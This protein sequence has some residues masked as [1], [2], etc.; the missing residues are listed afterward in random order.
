[1]K[2]FILSRLCPRLSITGK[3]NIFHNATKRN[4]S[5][6]VM[7]QK[8]NKLIAENIT[9]LTQSK[10]FSIQRKMIISRLKTEKV[11]TEQNLFA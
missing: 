9:K 11:E 2:I 3:S 1:M 10:V 7:Y 5:H 4:F 8:V 6:K